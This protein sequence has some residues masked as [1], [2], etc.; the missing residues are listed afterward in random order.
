[1]GNIVKIVYGVSHGDDGIQYD[2]SGM[3]RPHVEEEGGHLTKIVKGEVSGFIL[4]MHR[5]YCILNF[6]FII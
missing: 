3:D 2:A 1:V 6:L 5:N 4:P